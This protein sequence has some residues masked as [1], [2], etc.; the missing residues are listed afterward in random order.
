MCQMSVRVVTVA[1]DALGAVWVSALS[2]RGVRVLI[3]RESAAPGEVAEGYA[4]ALRQCPIREE[5]DA[6][7]RQL[8]LIA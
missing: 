3:V 6:T 5:L 8:T 1:D 2:D 4:D 7:K